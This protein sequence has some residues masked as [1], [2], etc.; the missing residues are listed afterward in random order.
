M[1]IVMDGKTLAD[2]IKL[3]IAESVKALQVEPHLAVVLV[4]DDPA[5]Q[6]YVRNKQRDCEE[7]GFK[8]TEYRLDANVS[9]SE[10]FELVKGL[11][12][13]PSVNG[14]LVQLPLPAHIDTESILMAITPYKDVDC[15]SSFNIGR[16]VKGGKGSLFLPC[17]PKGV[18]MLL[19]HYGISL[20]GKHCVIIGRS[21]I[22]G[23]PMALLALQENAT[24]T[25]CHSHTTNLKEICQTA[26]ILITAVGKA[27]LIKPDFV[28]DGVVVV[29][30]GMNRNEHGKLCGDCDPMV[31]DKSSAYTP[32][33]GGVG[34]M[35]RATLMLNTCIAAKL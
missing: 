30:C 27:G 20:D 28:K 33:P 10:L 14:I 25:V 13:D 4:G 31:Y 6:I 15:F 7:C 5:S 21:N 18:L 9:Q 16:L 29:D 26:D 17:T 22:V 32:V 23:K 24:V 3:K 19:N 12:K 34:P 11:S 35:T 1:P 2:K 8:S